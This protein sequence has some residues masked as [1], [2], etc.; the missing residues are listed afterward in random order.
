MKKGLVGLVGLSFAF[1][2]AACNN[3]VANEEVQDIKGMVRDYSVG[4]YNDVSASITSNELILTVKITR[5]LMTYQKMSF[6]FQLHHLLRQ[7]IPVQIIA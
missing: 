4:S 5:I 1:I 6:L 7:H 2:L 3:G